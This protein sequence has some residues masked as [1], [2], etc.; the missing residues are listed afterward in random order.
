VKRI[1]IT[2]ANSYVGTNVE[3]WLMK[4]PDKYHVDTIDMIDGSW[5]EKD[6]SGYDVVF[7]VAGIAHVKET[8][9]NRSLFY[10]VNR[11]LPI[12]VAQKAKNAGV[13]HFIFLSS[14]SVYGM[15]TGIISKTTVPIPKTNYG[16]SKLEAEDGIRALI[17]EKFKVAILRP[18]MIYGKGCKGNF[19][20]LVL[21]AQK[22]PIFPIISNTRSMLYI[23]NLS[24]FI[25]I[26]IEENLSG[27]YFPQNREFMNTSEMVKWI[28]SSLGSKVYLSRSLGVFISLLMRFCK[29]AR[30]AF[31]SLIYHEM[32]NF[33]HDY[34]IFDAE[35]SVRLSVKTY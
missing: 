2:G 12:E 30:K 14:M 8:S 29:P 20:K 10:L 28:A 19:Q 15:D 23:N 25:E 31:G 27:L 6:F 33:N 11:D 22:L 26:M 16:K 13:S 21:L 18:P 5:R 7:H 4:E 3:R 24:S 32:E 17:N 9:G 34:C 35:T 1:L